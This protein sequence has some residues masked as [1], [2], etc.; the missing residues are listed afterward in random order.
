MARIAGV[1]IPNHQ[2]VNI[3][4][5]AIYG[6]GRSSS[7]NICKSVGIDANIKIKETKTGKI[8]FEGTTNDKGFF[9]T[10]EFQTKKIENKKVESE[11]V[12]SRVC[13]ANGAVNDSTEMIKKGKE[14]VNLIKV[15]G[16][17]FRW[18]N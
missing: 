6:I 4:L 10:D 2:H 13:G 17:Q 3:A 1:N 7:K 9:I 12:K 15:F 11:I 18:N 5:T 16:I 8:Y 14:K